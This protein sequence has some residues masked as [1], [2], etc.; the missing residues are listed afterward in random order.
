MEWLASHYATLDCQNKVVKFE[1]PG[2]S[3]FSF[4]GE[5]G[6]APHNLISVLGAS[7]LLRKGC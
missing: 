2:E 5:Q 1:M 3:A 4:Q 7:K 6:W